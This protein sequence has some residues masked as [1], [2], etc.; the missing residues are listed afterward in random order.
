MRTLA[1]KGYMQI[2]VT[3]RKVS[4]LNNNNNFIRVMGWIDENI[5]HLQIFF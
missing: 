4:E 3:N 2:H 5:L 1:G